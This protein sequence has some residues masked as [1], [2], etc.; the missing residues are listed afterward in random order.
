VH[1]VINVA[2]WS[3]QRLGYEFSSLELLDQALTHK[4]HSGPNNERLEFL[5]DAV[6]GFVIAAELFRQLGDGDEGLLSRMRS[7]LV[8]SETLAEI[9]AD[10]NVGDLLKLGSGESRSGGHQ[11][12]SLMADAVE[13][14]L[15]A[16]YLDGGFS[17]VQTVIRRLYAERLEELPDPDDLKDPKTRLQE[18]LQGIGIELP[19]YS[20][21]SEA[22]PPHDRQFE[23]EC[24]MPELGIQTVG[25]GTSRR[26][27]E[28]AAAASALQT[29]QAEKH[30]SP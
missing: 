18:Y 4:S 27:A 23:I 13:A 20:V 10:L 7:T 25:E 1:Q 24:S 15:G 2:D 8:R 29:L 26:R 22:G 9:G 5:G 30:E 21:K 3:Q 19:H 11:R 14:V 12:R 28:Q 16:V 6:L 17:A